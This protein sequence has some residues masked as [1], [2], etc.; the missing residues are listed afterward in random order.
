MEPAEK[1]GEK[2]EVIQFR[3]N[4]FL[5]KNRI[6]LIDYNLSLPA[7]S[8]SGVSHI[9]AQASLH[10]GLHIFR[11]SIC[12]PSDIIF[13]EKSNRR[14]LCRVHGDRPPLLHHAALLPQGGRGQGAKIEPG[15]IRVQLSHK[16]KIILFVCLKS[17]ASSSPSPTC[18]ACSPHRSS[19]ATP[20]TWGQSASMSRPA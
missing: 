17:T 10:S 13:L 9:S 20:G 6:L 18:P 2:G 8:G 7:F 12:H 14:L 15:N 1:E 16:K 5:K 19:A 3:T 4:I 11:H